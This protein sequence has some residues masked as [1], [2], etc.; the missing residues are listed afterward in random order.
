[1]AARSWRGVIALSWSLGCLP[2]ATTDPVPAAA[3]ALAAT[4]GL[5]RADRALER[6]HESEA[7]AELLLVAGRCPTSSVERYALLTAAAIALDPSNESRQLDL[8]AS[9]TARYLATVPATDAAGRP[10]ARALYLLAVELGAEPSPPTGCASLVSDSAAIAALPHMGSPSVP[11]RIKSLEREL[12]R[13]RE[14][15]LRIRKTL[16]PS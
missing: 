14:E 10:L 9:L 7:I 4:P 5:E 8:G 11:D 1:M 2:K 12:T 6:G 13:L 3:P 16:E 15:L